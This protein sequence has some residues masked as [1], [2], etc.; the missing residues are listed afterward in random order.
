MIKFTEFRLDWGQ[1]REALLELTVYMAICFFFAVSKI[2]FHNQHYEGFSL[3]RL[4]SLN[5]KNFR[6]VKYKV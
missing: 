6:F 2:K 1:G 3:N 4:L 5:F